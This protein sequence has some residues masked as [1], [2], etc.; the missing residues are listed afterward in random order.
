MGAGTA[1]SASASVG[2][3]AGLG[4]GAG[5]GISA[6][7]GIGASASA[8][9]IVGL[10][11][12]A[13]VDAGAGISAGSE[14]SAGAAVGALPPRGARGQR[15][16]RIFRS[17]YQLYILMLPA[18]VATLI[19]AYGPMYGVQIAFKDF[20]SRLGIWGSKWVGLEHFVRFFKYPSFLQM[21][22]NTLVISLYDLATFPLSIILALLLNE[23]RS[24]KFRK[25]VQMVSY[26]P[27]FLST[28]VLCGIVTLF[29]GKG[30]GLL[31]NL[32]EMAGGARV[33]FLI[34]PRYFA[35]IYVWSGVWQDIGWGSIIYIAALSGVSPELVEAARMDGAGRLRVIWHVNLPAILPTIIILQ[36]MA[37]G[38]ILS[39]GFEKILLLQNDLNMPA[40]S[41]ISTYVYT[42]GV[43]R[44]QYSYST[45]IGLFNNLI[46]VFVLTIVNKISD[47]LS[48][49]ALW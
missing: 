40:S 4:A 21:L 19:F 18:I 24:T 17:N 13:S 15:A 33:D 32:L 49:V 34:V 48:G 8:A 6:N 46:N 23:I 47:K 12:G 5:A 44:G 29:L 14:A 38:R 2:T 16:R 36:I 10:G 42:L 41:V 20:S 45:A 30:D 22:R 11:A 3:G 9:T 26:A 1:A 31:N 27:H 43:L 35:S 39:V 28:V 7:E 25:T 37:A